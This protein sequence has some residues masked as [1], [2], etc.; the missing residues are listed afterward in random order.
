MDGLAELEWRRVRVQGEIDRYVATLG[1]NDDERTHLLLETALL[2]R[3]NIVIKIALINTTNDEERRR[4]EQQIETNKQLIH[5]LNQFRLLPTQQMQV[6]QQGNLIFLSHF[7][8]SYCFIL[9]NFNE[10]IPAIRE[11]ILALNENTKELR[12]RRGVGERGSSYDPTP[13]FW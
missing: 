2:N 13:S 10:L 4:K 12:I 7:V 11:L 3:E 1:D 6:A 5:D 9:V 8:S